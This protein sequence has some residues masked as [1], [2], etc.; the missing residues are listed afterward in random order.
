MANRI[1]SCPT[2]GATPIEFRIQRLLG[3][4]W[5]DLPECVFRGGS[6]HHKVHET[7][8]Q[9]DAEFNSKHRIVALVEAEQW[10]R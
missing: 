7:K 1:A 4:E 6:A 10:P 8:N 5:F 2:C 9:L 3:R